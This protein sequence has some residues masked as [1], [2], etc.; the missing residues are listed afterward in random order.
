MIPMQALL[1]GSDRPRVV[2]REVAVDTGLA[3]GFLYQPLPEWV[4]PVLEWA[5]EP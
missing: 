2:L 5:R 4:N 1:D 3:H